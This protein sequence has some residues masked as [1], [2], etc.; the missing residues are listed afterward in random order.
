REFGIAYVFISHDMAVVERMCHRVAVMYLGEVVEYGP[1]DE[2]ISRPQHAYTR[3]LLD[4][5]PIADPAKRRNRALM[6]DE[7]PSPIKPLG[8]E[9]VKRPMVEVGPDHFVQAV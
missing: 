1:R 4:S 2:V 9:P 7:I 8:F 5:V 6:T 3:R